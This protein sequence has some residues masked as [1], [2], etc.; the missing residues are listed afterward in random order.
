MSRFDEVEIDRRLAKRIAARLTDL[1][2]T[3]GGTNEKAAPKL[4]LGDGVIGRLPWM[5]ER[6]TGEVVEAVVP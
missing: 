5:A 1:V 6:E 4:G 2:A 3:H